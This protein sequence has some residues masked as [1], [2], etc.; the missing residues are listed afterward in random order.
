MTPNEK[1]IF[2][3]TPQVA[4][5]TLRSLLDEG[6]RVVAVVT[7]PDRPFGRGLKLAPSPVK[8]LALSVGLPILQPESARSPEL[9][10]ELQRYEADLFV[11]VAYGK[12]LPKRLLALPRLAPINLHFSLLPKYR[13]AA[14]VNHALIHGETR[15]GVTV[16]RMVKRMDA[17]EI[18]VQREVEI[19]PEETAPELFQRLTEL[20]CSALGEAIDLLSAGEAEFRPQNEDE[21]SFAPLL[22]R[23]D[24]RLDFALPARE[25]YNRWRGLLGRSGV[26]C[27]LGGERLKIHQCELAT[28]TEGVDLSAIEAGTVIEITTAGWLV[29]CG[30]DGG[31]DSSLLRITEVQAPNQKRLPAEVFA[32]GRRLVAPFRLS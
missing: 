13:G 17:G 23:E 31:S 28:P 8:E 3:G 9:I 2:F 29:V 14:P 20:G 11:V 30:T 15:S 16:Q 18:I 4:A 5:T 21:A 6:R 24:G 1:I 19:A 26:H 25:L 27:E 7:N 12:F 32:N 10:E 22:S